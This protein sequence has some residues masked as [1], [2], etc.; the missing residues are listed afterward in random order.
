LNPNNNIKLKS[1]KE[2]FVPNRQ[3]KSSDTQIQTLNVEKLVPFKNHPFKL[4]EGARFDDMIESIKENGIIMPV[5]VRP[6]DGELYEILSGHNRVKAAKFIGLETV[7]VVIRENLT[8]DEVMLI[9][10]E[11]NLI[12]R[13][14]ADLTPSE[15]AAA[16]AVHHESVKHQ[17]KRMDLINEIEELLKNSE[18][19]KTN[20]N[21]PAF[22]PL[23]EKIRADKQTAEKYELS[24]RN[25]SRYLRIHRLIPELKQQV[26]SEAISIRAAVELSYLAD[27]H[28][29]IINDLIVQSNY[30]IDIK[31]SELLREYSESGTLTKERITNILSNILV[32]NKKKTPS[33][34]QPVKITG[35]VLS[36]YFKPEQTAQEIQTELIEALEFYRAS[37]K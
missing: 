19:H 36:K 10:T 24:S 37:K 33:S 32:K 16:I 34:V 2:I 23:G 18:N 21:L 26:D 22:R 1:F 4:Y 7:P 11:T 12:Q 29:F 14:F 3:N 15:K 5:I 8:D 20:L 30:K 6:I 13:S 17:G 35:K 9:V 27:T 28:Q 31:K 25:V